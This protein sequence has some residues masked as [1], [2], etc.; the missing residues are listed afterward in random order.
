MRTAVKHYRH[1]PQLMGPLSF[2]LSANDLLFSEVSS[3]IKPE[4]IIPLPRDNQNP[5]KSDKHGPRQAQPPTA[6]LGQDFASPPRC[7]P[8]PQRPASGAQGG[9][10][11]F[12]IYHRPPQTPFLSQTQSLSPP[13]VPPLSPAAGLGPPAAARRGRAERPR[14][15]VPSAPPLRQRHRHPGPGPCPGPGPGS[16][17]RPRPRASAPTS[18]SPPVPIPAPGA[19]PLPA[20]L[21]PRGKPGESLL[22]VGVGR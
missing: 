11:R 5:L 16:G 8:S 14:G 9:D 21:P 22:L 7:Q 4:R 2:S 12:W 1:R 20:A 3:Q 6:R 13:P 17:S 18:Y 10:G 19:A 15:A